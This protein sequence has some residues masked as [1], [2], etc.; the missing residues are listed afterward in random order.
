MKEFRILVGQTGSSSLHTV[1][2]NTN[3]DIWLQHIAREHCKVA[4]IFN[5]AADRLTVVSIRRPTPHERTK[6]LTLQMGFQSMTLLHHITIT[7]THCSSLWSKESCMFNTD[8]YTLACGFFLE[9]SQASPRSEI[10][11]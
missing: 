8:T 9:K 5:V 1:C 10:R 2:F 7:P 6:S 11:T 3:I 4:M